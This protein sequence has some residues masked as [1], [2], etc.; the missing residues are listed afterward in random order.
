[1]Y[2]N[3]VKT[4]RKLRALE[5]GRV[6]LQSPLFYVQSPS[7]WTE[8]NQKRKTRKHTKNRKKDKGADKI[9]PV[10]GVT[11]EK[12]TERRGKRKKKEEERKNC[13]ATRRTR[14]LLRTVLKPADRGSSIVIM[15]KYQYLFEGMRQFNTTHYREL[16]NLIFEQTVSDA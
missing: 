15:D 7:S 5:T 3:R 11:E 10:L 12:K 4:A 1:M 8:P 16:D 2:V 14:P 13:G 9:W 6:G